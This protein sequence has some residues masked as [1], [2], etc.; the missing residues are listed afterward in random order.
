MTRL[1]VPQTAPHTHTLFVYGT[2]LKENY[3]QT[4]LVGWKMYDVGAYP[5]IV[6]S[7]EPSDEVHGGLMLVDD[8]QLM[9][10]DMYEGVP[11]LYRREAV[12]TRDGFEVEVYT[13]NG[14]T[15]GLQ[16]ITTGRWNDRMRVRTAPAQLML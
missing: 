10:L 15:E 11:T 1:T 13:W 12:V 16:E 8:T 4:V 5:G 2:L 7:A 3:H 6:R 14:Q 9:G